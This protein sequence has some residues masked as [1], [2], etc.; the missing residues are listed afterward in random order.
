MQIYLNEFLL[1][2]SALFLALLSP[3]PDFAITVKQ[4]V[5]YGKKHAIFTSLG[6]GLGIGVHIVYT[7]FGIGLLISQ[8]PIL[9]NTIK[10]IGALYLIYLGYQNIV[11]KGMFLNPNH[12]NKTISLKKSFTMG[13]FCNV[14]N[15]KATIFFI[16]IF[17][18]IVSIDTPIYIQ[19]LYGLFCMLAN[20]L[21][22]SLLAIILEKR[23][24]LE[25]FN[26]NQL[27]FEKLIGIIL[28]I[29]GIYII[30]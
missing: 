18:A 11:S 15:P 16:S 8:S 13:F 30:F 29:L 20:F 21:W 28:V 14:L 22:Y 24:N 27:L 7:L 25:L 3:G 9:F 17:T 12:K 4:T 1:L 6:I 23:K 26:K 5:N 10:I 2:S 19:A